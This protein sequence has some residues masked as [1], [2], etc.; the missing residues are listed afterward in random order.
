MNKRYGYNTIFPQ[1]SASAVLLLALSL[2]T[3]T[4]LANLDADEASRMTQLLAMDLN[5]LVN[6]EVSIATGTA[7]PLKLAPAIATVITAEDIKKMGATTLEEA[8][9]TVP[10]LHVSQS[11]TLGMMIYSI[12][13]LHTTLSSQVLFQ[14]N[15]L[16]IKYNY[17]SI[18]SHDLRIPMT[19]ISR[20]EV[21][22]GP[23]SA[24]HGADAFAG[25]IN[26]ITKKGAE[27]DGTQTNLRYGSFDTKSGGIQH[28]GIYNEW[29]LMTSFDYYKTN[30]D[31][32]RIIERDL[33]T[34][35]DTIMGTSAS[36]TPGSTADETEHYDLRLTATKENW[37]LNLWG[38]IAENQHVVG[39]SPVLDTEGY[40][41]RSIYQADLA[42][43]NNTLLDNLELDARLSY[44]YQYSDSFCRIFP[45][46]VLLPVGA[47][48]NLLT[49]PTAGLVLFSDGVFGQPIIEEEQ[50]AVDLSGR[51]NGID[52]HKVRL[53][54]GGRHITEKTDN[55]KNFGPGVLDPATLLAPPA[56]NVIDGNLTHL[57]SDSPYIFMNN[58][59]RTIVYA[60]LQ[61][62]WSFAKKWELTAG[63][64][65]DHYSDF[66]STTNPRAA[67]VWET[68]D[69]ITSKLL[70]GKAFRPPSF[71]EFYLI[72]NP[73][74]LGNPDLK[75]ET[76]ET[77]E[78]VFDLQPRKN[79][80]YVFNA[81]YYQAEDLIELANDPAPAI[82]LSSQNIRNQ[83]GHG[84]EFEATWQATKNLRLRGNVAHQRAKDKQTGEIVP[85]APAWQL[86]ANA[87]WQFIPDWS[88]D[89]QYFLIAERHRAAGDSRAEIK[90]NDIVNLTLRRTNIAGHWEATLSGRNVFDEDIREPTPSTIANDLPM[91][92]RNIWAELAYRF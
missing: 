82:T 10:G 42:Y 35:L 39:V 83:K 43:T 50:T 55:Y 61:D 32:D 47:D 49:A 11:N 7:K 21:I 52:N 3:G 70:Y 60:S 16:P 64:R 6:M 23:G 72:N 18:V 65:Y 1:V 68:T 20:I 76:I 59:S 44:L 34:T 73:V 17:T 38:S 85:N 77:Y 78:L 14:I 4:A 28:G 45:P 84:F 22:R 51:Y 46:G 92:G 15:G 2:S 69:T 91:P 30:G 57:T 67:L 8:L 56:I 88:L 25:T 41:E 29:D 79:I 74:A 24:V 48:G 26:I 53:G 63:I 89:G 62:E 13:G 58:H 86:Y 54:A 80:H 81:F 40:E 75:P 71:G 12:R 33:Q 90:N 5:E 31:H 9:A 19:T 87:H 27:I 66:G 36:L 37:S